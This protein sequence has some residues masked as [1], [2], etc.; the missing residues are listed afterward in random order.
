MI[1][2]NLLLRE[3][4]E[5]AIGHGGRPEGGGKWGY[6]TGLLGKSSRLLAIAL[7]QQPHANVQGA[8]VDLFLGWRPSSICI[9]VGLDCLMDQNR[10]ALL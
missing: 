2:R 4:S 8:V 9:E 6:L 3:V 5:K 1:T 10:W 7:L